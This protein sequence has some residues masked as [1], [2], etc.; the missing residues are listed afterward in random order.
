MWFGGGEETGKRI[1]VMKSSISFSS[2]GLPNGDENG[3][4]KSDGDFA[5][6]DLRD[7]EDEEDERQVCES[8]LPIVIYNCK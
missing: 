8:R 5:M 7:G 4:E 3:E 2:V 1:S 6:E